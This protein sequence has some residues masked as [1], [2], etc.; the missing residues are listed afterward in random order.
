MEVITMDSTVYENLVKKIDLIVNF[1]EE[2]KK[3]GIDKEQWVETSDVC[4]FLNIS[5]KTLSRLRQRGEPSAS[6]R[7]NRALKDRK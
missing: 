1:I 7:Q 4:R 2:Q 5:V 3:N 6:A